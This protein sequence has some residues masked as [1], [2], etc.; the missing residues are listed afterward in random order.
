MAED[1]LIASK[2]ANL[3]FEEAAA[4]S[5]GGMNALGFLCGKAGIKRGWHEASF[6]AGRKQ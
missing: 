6:A 1:G 3:T 2:P 5:F 4:L